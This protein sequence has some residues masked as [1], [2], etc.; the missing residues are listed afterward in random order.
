MNMQIQKKKLMEDKNDTHYEI[1]WVWWFLM[2]LHDFDDFFYW[3]L[4]I[5]SNVYEFYE[6]NATPHS[7]I[8]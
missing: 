6:L 1:V 2:N 4:W 8:L 7:T 5:L 3:I